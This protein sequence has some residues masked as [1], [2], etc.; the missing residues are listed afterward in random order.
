MSEEKGSETRTRFTSTQLTK[1]RVSPRYFTWMTGLSF[2]AVTLNGQCF[3]SRFTSGSS[4]L[5]PMRRF[6]SKTVFSGLE[7]NAFLAESPTL[8]GK[9]QY[10]T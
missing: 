3:M 7:W 4:T 2:F 8:K 5:R 6:A 10:R 1:S 9:F